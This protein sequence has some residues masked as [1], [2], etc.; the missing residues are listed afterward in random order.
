MTAT[1]ENGSGRKCSPLKARL[2]FS[3]VEEAT[4]A[5]PPKEKP[6]PE[7]AP[8]SASDIAVKFYGDR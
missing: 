7:Q 1:I 6:P 2:R 8:V 5:P 3:P 4:K